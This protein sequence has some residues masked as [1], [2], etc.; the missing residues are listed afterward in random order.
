MPQSKK[1]SCLLSALDDVTFRIVNK[2][3]NENDR[4][5]VNTI[6]AHMRKRFTPPHRDGQMRLLFR[7]C[8]QEP[9]QDL[10]SFYTELLSKGSKAFKNDNSDSMEMNLLDQFIIGITEETIR[11]HLIERRHTIKTVK[12][13]LDAA[14]AYREAVN[15]NK[16]ITDKEH[17]GEKTTTNT[18]SAVNYRGRSSFRYTRGRSRG[19]GQSSYRGRGNSYQSTPR[20]YGNSRDTDGRPKCYNCGKFGHM[21]RAC[22]SK[23][24]QGSSSGSPDRFQNWRDKRSQSRSNSHSPYRTSNHS[25]SRSPSR[26]RESSSDRYRRNKSDYRDTDEEQVRSPIQKSS[27]GGGKTTS[28]VQDKSRGQPMYVEG[29]IG[30]I[31]TNLFIDCG[32]ATTIISETMFRQTTKAE[33]KHSSAKLETANGQQL[34]VLGKI[35]LNV[36]IGGTT[37]KE[38]HFKT[39]YTFYVVK[40]LAHDVLLGLDFL[41]LHKAVIDTHH[42]KLTIQDNY[43]TVTVHKLIN[44][45]SQYRKINVINKTEIRIPARSEILIQGKLDD[46]DEESL[47]GQRHR[48]VH[49]K[50]RRRDYQPSAAH[51]LT[52]VHDK[53]IPIRLV[54]PLMKRQCSSA[55]PY[56]VPLKI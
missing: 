12:Q 47:Q 35:K 41:A 16:N 17:K 14:I 24:S 11:L 37:R 23:Y 4:R 29:R 36:E 28:A 53:T 43:M 56:S 33:M 13:A 46:M 25:Q 27:Y 10:Q 9:G 19:R 15:Y 44:L 48:P 6:K 38:G 42:R 54:N 34:H 31:D 2:E 22:Y 52:T 45:Q 51:V 49:A 26:E 3:L 7:N 21:A 5:N 40:E 32:S 30:N 8:K 20:Q 1:A 50:Q 39:D 18:V 55:A